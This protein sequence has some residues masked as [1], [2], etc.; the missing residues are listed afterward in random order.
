MY[1]CASTA[2]KTSI[3]TEWLVNHLQ[4][5]CSISVSECQP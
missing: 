4:I 5:E 1:F 2:E 3:V